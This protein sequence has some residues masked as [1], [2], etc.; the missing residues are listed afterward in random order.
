MALDRTK[1]KADAALAANRTVEAIKETLQM[2]SEEQTADEV[3]DG[4][5]GAER[6]GEELPAA[7]DRHSRRARLQA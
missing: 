1:I 3:E 6:W 2:L 7:L 4:S 5:Y